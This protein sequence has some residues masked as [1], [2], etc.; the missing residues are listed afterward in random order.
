MLVVLLLTAVSG[1]VWL[2]SGAFAFA[3]IALDSLA[4]A[5]TTGPSPMLF[6]LI[7]FGWVGPALVLL[8]G[9]LAAPHLGQPRA[10]MAAAGVLVIQLLVA[11]LILMLV[12]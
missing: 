3:A 10:K 6:N 8:V 1:L 5:R 4:G 9:L 11:T 2:G 7:I 12:A